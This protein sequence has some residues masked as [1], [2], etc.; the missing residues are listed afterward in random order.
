MGDGGSEM[1]ARVAAALRGLP[2][3]DRSAEGGELDNLR[4]REAAR[5]AIA[6][7]REPTDD[8]SERMSAHASNGMV[9][10]RDLHYAMID[11]ALGKPPA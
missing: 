5:A 10:W 1:V 7:M 3:R 4:L 11:A 8:V 6:A 9:D 2:V